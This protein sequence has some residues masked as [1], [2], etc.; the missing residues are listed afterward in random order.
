[1]TASTGADRSAIGEPAETGSPRA[2]AHRTD[3]RRLLSAAASALLVAQAVALALLVAARPNMSPSTVDYLV[4]VRVPLPTTSGVNDLVVAEPDL[5]VAGIALLVIAAA[6]IGVSAVRPG[7]VVDLVTDSQVLAI[8]AV[9]VALATGVADVPA[10]MLVY[11]AT[12]SMVAMTGVSAHSRDMR[13]YMI[14]AALGIVPWGTFG[15]VQV[16][17]AIIGT[18]GPTVA[19]RALT[20]V[21]LVL[22]AAWSALAWARIRRPGADRRTLELGGLAVRIALPTATAALLWS[23]GR[24]AG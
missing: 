6:G 12:A 5:V 20:L 17:A 23:A 7:P 10:L 9:L 21:T 4:P 18:D 22:V 11:A 14:G 2:G 19:V 13:P 24:G 1:M 16:G 15:V 8:A 3:R